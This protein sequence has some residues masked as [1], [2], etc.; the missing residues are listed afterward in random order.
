MGIPKGVQSCEVG[1]WVEGSKNQFHELKILNPLK[2]PGKRICMKYCFMLNLL[3]MMRSGLSI[4][5]IMGFWLSSFLMQVQNGE[6]PDI[7]APLSGQALQGVVIINGHTALKNFQSAE[8]SYSYASSDSWFL[9]SQSHNPVE[10]DRLAVWDTTT[11]TDGDYKLR[12]QVFLTGGSVVEKV[13]Q[14]R[15]RNYSPVE[16][17]TIEPTQGFVAA[18]PT[19]TV[20]PTAILQPTPTDLAPNPAIVSGGDLGRSMQLGATGSV[21]FLAVLGLY[22]FYKQSRRIK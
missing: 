4:L 9:I 16:T 10:S 15:V 19:A 21:L 13:I 12:V 6:Q 17:A 3:V 14:V 22:L 18:R 5:I 1:K 8:I 11:I 2:I 7:T 20:T